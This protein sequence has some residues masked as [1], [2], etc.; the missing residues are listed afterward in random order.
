MNPIVPKW[1]IVAV[2]GLLA[3][4][5]VFAS[6]DKV[7]TLS[8]KMSGKNSTN[9][10]SVSSDG[11]AKAIPD[12][13]TVNLG[14]VTQG[15]TSAN[16]QEENSKKINQIIDFVKQQGIN[17]DDISTSQFSI[18]PQYNY[19]NGK[20]EIIGYEARQTITVQ[21]RGVDK[22]TVSL[23]KIL[24]GATTAGV[25]E[26]TGVSLSFVDTDSLTK[27]A[28]E[29]ALKKAKAKAEEMAA[30]AGIKLGRVVS[31]TES[32]S[33]G[34]PLP[35]YSQGLGGYGGGMEA[36]KSISPNVEP[37]TQEIIQNVSISYEIK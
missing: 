24:S 18:Y 33:Y 30:A 17:R 32:S 19:A 9:I 2:G 37:G 1:L 13:A 16:V 7:Q 15:T 31:I 29:E 11:K 27:K 34:G 26:I 4:F 12:M 5:L 3:I 25:N 23:G 21:V 8:D 14:V 20:N 36:S 35:Y 10:L 22:S 28:R 6:V